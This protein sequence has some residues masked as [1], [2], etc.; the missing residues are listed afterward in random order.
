MV[1]RVSSSNV[2]FAEVRK[3]KNLTIPVLQVNKT[4]KVILN[5]IK[6]SGFIGGLSTVGFLVIKFGGIAIAASNPISLALAAIFV[7]AAAIFGKSCFYDLPKYPDL[8]SQKN[9]IVDAT[10]TNRQHTSYDPVKNK[11]ILRTFST[12]NPNIKSRVDKLS[13]NDLNRLHTKLNGSATDESI[14][15]AL[16]ELELEQNPFA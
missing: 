3:E 9:K 5:R 12:V 1:N 2:R 8:K 16:Y 15:K 6:R 13:E 10:K 7:P 11:S 14:S 4:R